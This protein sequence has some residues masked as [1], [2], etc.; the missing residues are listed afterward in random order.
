M[1]YDLRG[2]KTKLVS[3]DAGTWTYA[4]N[5]LREMIRQTDA[6]GQITTQFNDALGRLVEPWPHSR[7][8]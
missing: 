6:K 2:R 1:T 4:Y 3:P 7:R 5:G 8:P